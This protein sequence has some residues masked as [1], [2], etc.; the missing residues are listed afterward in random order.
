MGFHAD[1]EAARLLGES[2]DFSRQGQAAATALRA[3]APPAVDPTTEPVRGVTPTS[4]VP[5]APS[6]TP[7]AGDGA[8][9]P[10]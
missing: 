5:T 10:R 9:E 4:K 2:I 7:P 1:Q 6:T 8:R 3:P